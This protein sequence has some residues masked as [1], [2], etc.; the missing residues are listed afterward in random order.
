MFLLIVSIT[1]GKL[2]GHGVGTESN[3]CSHIVAQFFV[4]KS[5]ENNKNQDFVIDAEEVEEDDDETSFHTLVIEHCINT[6][7]TFFHSTSEYSFSLL[8]HQLSTSK[9]TPL[10]LSNGALRL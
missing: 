8:I 2:S 7:I 6:Y 5:P 4:D 9:D 1:F 10:F 3:D